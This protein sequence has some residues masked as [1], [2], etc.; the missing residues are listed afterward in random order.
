MELNNIKRFSV[1][2]NPT[3]IKGILLTKL[4]IINE[5]LYDHMNSKN[6][7]QINFKENKLLICY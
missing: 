1:I 2:L 6:T 5:Y 3:A 4:P 7:L